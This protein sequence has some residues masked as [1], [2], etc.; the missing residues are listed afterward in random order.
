[1]KNKIFI[2]AWWEFIEKA[3]NKTF[4]FSTFLMPIVIVLV[5]LI[6][7]FLG[8]QNSAAPLAIGILD[9]TG[10]YLN[11]FENNM[12][13]FRLEDSQPKYI[14]L[15]LSRRNKS[16]LKNEIFADSLLKSK[17]LEGYILIKNKKHKLIVQLING[18]NLGH[19]NIN[20]F[21][22]AFNKT[23]L[24]LALKKFGITPNIINNIAPQIKISDIEFTSGTNTNGSFI[25]IFIKFYAV[26]I[27]LIIS[28]LLAGG[29]FARSLVEERSNGII[30]ILFSSCK[31][32]QLLSGKI[33]GLSL[34]G[35]FQ[36]FIWV[37]F[38]LIITKNEVFNPAFFNNL[39][40]QILFFFIGFIF[41][42]TIYTAIGIIAKTD[43][44]VQ[45][46]SSYLSLLLILPL[47]LSVYVIPH[48][49][50]GLSLFLNYFP[51][52][53]TPI[54]ILRLNVI[55]LPL[56]EI[57]LTLFINIISIVIIIKLSSKYFSK[58]VLNR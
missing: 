11:G 25:M 43:H 36:L 6:P 12:K 2:I 40:L 20:D 33:L 42:I 44:E 28:I 1:M 10:I 31:G 14:L 24:Q 56:Y 4:L 19:E 13:S 46:F 26:M 16:I 50:S 15:N 49:N 38:G 35:I 3:K 27:I 58:I 21:Q 30:E 54:M 39:G 51:F 45:Q 32:E 55:S 17:T 53:S 37:I 41:Y 22:N 5:G 23:R 57:I 47:I 52:T 8:N 34:L 18:G 7:S 48:P 9:E 29:M